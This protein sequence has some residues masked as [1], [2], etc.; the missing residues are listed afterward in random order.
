MPVGDK[1]GLRDFLSFLPYNVCWFLTFTMVDVYWGAWGSLSFHSVL[2][3][4]IRGHLG[5]GL[6]LQIGT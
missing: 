3:E 1:F 6:S 2:L 4:G 5:G